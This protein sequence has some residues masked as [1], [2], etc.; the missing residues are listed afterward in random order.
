MYTV[1]WKYVNKSTITK[2][3]CNFIIVSFSH[4][5][6]IGMWTCGKVGKDCL[7]L[8]EIVYASGP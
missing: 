7:T 1:K 8:R 5:E 6:Y 3:G 4:N 2:L